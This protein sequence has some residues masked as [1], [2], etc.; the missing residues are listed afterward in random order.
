MS[1]IE[2]GLSIF[3]FFTSLLTAI[4][5]VGGGMILI[6]AMVGVVPA[7]ALVPV[8]AVIQLASNVSRAG[9]G[10]Q[11]IR[12]EYMT[13]FVVGSLIAG[14]LGS[15]FIRLINLDYITAFVAVF[16]LLSVWLPNWINVLLNERSE[17][18]SIG[19][20]QTGLGT[21]GGTTGPLA[22]A[23]LMRLGCARDEVVTT[24]AA[25]MSVT[26][27]IKITAFSLLGVSIWSWWPLMTGMSAGVILG[28]WVGTRSR[29]KLDE[30]LFKRIVN[31]LLT[32][33][34]LRM[35]YLTFN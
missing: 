12:W 6:A 32:V 26:H 34:A 19:V 9:F 10:W 21:M 31:I 5:G 4:T 14:A 13:A 16:I 25:Q 28:S 27:L 35:L 1:S 33:L 2:I 3:S 11:H 15:Q 18:F 24:V 29:A 22:N 23:S 20:V 8:H 7:A 17:M 30:Q